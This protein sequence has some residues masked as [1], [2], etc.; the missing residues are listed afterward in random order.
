VGE[1]RVG[2]VRGVT[3]PSDGVPP[4][5]DEARPPRPTTPIEPPTSPPAEATGPREVAGGSLFSRPPTSETPAAA[6]PTERPAASRPTVAPS[7]SRPDTAIDSPAVAAGAT[8]AAEATGGVSVSGA[9]RAT[10]V[11]EVPEAASPS[12]RHRRR[13]RSWLQRGVLA[14]NTIAIALCLLAAGSLAFA[15]KQ[16]SEITRIGLGGLLTP[17]E[18]ESSLEPRNFLLVGIDNDIGLADGDPVKV[19]RDQTLNTDTIMVL[20]VDPAAHKAWMLS[21][22]RDLW[23]KVPGGAN[24]RINTALSLGGPAKLIETIQ[25]EFGIPI[26]H[27][28]QVNFYGFEQLVSAIGGVPIYLDKPVRDQQTGLFQY[29]AGCVT[30]EGSQA[31]A[32]VRSRHLEVQNGPYQWVEDPSSDLGRIRR[33]QEFMRAALVRAIDKGARNPVTLNQLID[34]AKTNVQ[35][36]GSLT[37]QQLVDIGQ[38]F[39]DFD[40]E[41]LEVFQPPTVG[42][43]MGAAA[44]L[45]LQS[46]QAQPIFDIFRG[47]NP[48]LNLLKVVRVEVRNGTGRTD[49]GKEV[50]S[51]LTDAGFT[52]PRTKD[53]ASF[54]TE[55]TTVRYAPTQKLLGVVLARFLDGPV[56]FEEDP[57]LANSDTAVALVVGNDFGGVRTEARP[58][59]DFRDQLT[60]ERVA[61]LESQG[62]AAQAPGTTATTL[63]VTTSEVQAEV[64]KAPDSQQ[65]A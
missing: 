61:F 30:L 54:R 9:T 56:A 4:V 12:G 41:T 43:F 29:T 45:Q 22:P 26:N 18:D 63:P 21:F 38:E 7:S 51:A 65:C 46:L 3:A 17:T 24:G 34:V 48:T 58:E 23:V 52:V 31:L 33:Q 49:Q 19:G 60:P 15:Q 64:P 55:H 57:A 10:N 42:T 39:R 20:R 16:T 28:V 40:P 50:A 13:R 47:A 25:T 8:S 32:Y 62:S 44:V 35:I 11:V 36:D 27:Y 1:G 6:R 37:P 5:G 53:A 14:L 2:T 59:L